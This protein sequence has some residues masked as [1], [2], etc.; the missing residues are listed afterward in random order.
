MTTSADSTSTLAS[1][2]WWTSLV[3]VA[4]S[5]FTVREVRVRERL[6]VRCLGCH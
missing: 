5:P 2:N 1:L 4:R 3:K 6:F